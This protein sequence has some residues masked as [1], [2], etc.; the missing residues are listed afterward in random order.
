M[1]NNMNKTKKKLFEKVVINDNQRGFLFKNGK[2]EKM[3]APGKY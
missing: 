3:L 2:Y 1:K